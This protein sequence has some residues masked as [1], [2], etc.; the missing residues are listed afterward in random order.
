MTVSTE[1]SSNEYTGNGV[2]TDFDYKFRIFKANQLS[3]ITSDADGD[4]VVTLRLG[5][6]YTVTNANKAAGGKVIL[7]K[8]LA[9]GH[10]IS[11]AR[12][13][14][15]TQET[16][17]RNQSKF[18]AETH[19]DAFDYLTMIVQ[20]IWGSLG[21]LYLK[22]PN[23]L[24][25]WFDAKGYRIANLGKPKRDSDAVDLGT[26]KDEI[27]GVNSTI[28]KN[29]KRL[30]RVDDVD[31]PALPKVSERRNKQIGF[32]NSGIPTLLD[33]VETGA[34]GYVLVDSFEEGALITSRYQALHFEYQGEYYRWD[35]DLPKQVPAGSTPQSTGGIGKGAWV[36]VG[37]ASLRSSRIFTQ[38]PAGV[39]LTD[40]VSVKDYGAIG[41]GVI[42]DTAA[43][44]LAINEN[45]CVFFPDGIYKITKPLKLLPYKCI[46]GN[47]NQT[48]IKEGWNCVIYKASNALDDAGI[49]CIISAHDNTTS[50]ENANK[51]NSGSQRVVGIALHG[52]NSSG[53][54]GVITA[55]GLD[56]SHNE[57]GI[58]Y[59]AGGGSE[60]TNISCVNTKY[61][62]HLD[63]SWLTE[64]TNFIAYG[65]I[66]N[67]GGTSTN[68]KG[69]FA[70]WAVEG[71]FNF[72]GLM[73][74]TMIGCASD[75]P[76]KSAY[77]F[78]NCVLEML[79]CGQ[80]FFLVRDGDPDNYPTD[81]GIFF[82]FLGGNKITV[83]SHRCFNRRD[84]INMP[85]PTHD[86]YHITATTD[87][88][89]TFVGGELIRS[90]PPTEEGSNDKF[91]YMMYLKDNAKVFSVNPSRYMVID[92]LNI[93]Q[94]D[95]NSSYSYIGSD[96]ILLNGV[97]NNSSKSINSLTKGVFKPHF[98]INGNTS[99][100]GYI[101]QK[102]TF[103]K[104][105]NQ[106]TLNF[107]LYLNS[108]NGV[109]GNLDIRGIPFIASNESSGILIS[110]NFNSGFNGAIV[111]SIDSGTGIIKLFQANGFT[112]FTNASIPSQ[113]FCKISGSI[114][115]NV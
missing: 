66:V 56:L 59:G 41:D 65:S 7:T 53:K 22:R 55:G 105:G 73:Y 88:Y 82:N 50:S 52:N 18:F 2:T 14:P 109:S 74:S 70:G 78:K 102:C 31:I 34:L 49:D 107:E 47:Q 46:Y 95:Q 79:G 63:Q 72:E 87:D 39:S 81:Y 45:Q 8:P 62:L 97:E 23:I 106:V 11:I 86:V 36:S 43:L 27:S 20:R 44:Q 96:G 84:V 16:S 37:D 58:Y 28:L 61:A 76:M 21:S 100:F 32:D 26:L 101:S 90:L 80:E 71:G 67:R 89:I 75:L 115:F 68:F 94:D 114:T 6:D 108:F 113:P 110:R 38:R 30:L 4:N 5:T 48:L 35:G 40:I 54:Y 10:K 24:A 25:N 111:A 12:D 33:P 91:K 60:F 42:D 15:I 17:F 77:T 103:T 13:I 57:F 92:Y 9:D 69:C 99:G 83:T 85:S 29:E 51:L 112:A 64:V 104:I 1:I 98:S 93:K 19:E 3:V